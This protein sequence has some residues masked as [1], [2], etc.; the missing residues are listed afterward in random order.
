MK[1]QWPLWLRGRSVG[2]FSEDKSKTESSLNSGPTG[3]KIQSPANMV[4]HH[5]SHLGVDEGGF[6]LH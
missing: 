4:F 1:K 2:N 3:A 5:G 6:Q